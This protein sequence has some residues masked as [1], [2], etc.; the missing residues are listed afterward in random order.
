MPQSPTPDKVIDIPGVGPVAF[1]STMAP[2]DIETAAGRLHRQANPTAKPAEAPKSWLSTAV[3]WL[4]SIGGLAGGVIGGAGG[5][6]FG[7]GFGGVPGAV[8]GSALGGAAGEAL[9]QS[10][11]RLMGDNAPDSPIGA[12][13]DIAKQVGIQGGS[14]L[15]GGSVIA[16]MIKPV[17]NRL[18]ATFVQSA[19]KPGLKSTMRSV[20]KGADPEQIP[21]IKTLIDEGVNV[22]SAGIRKLNKIIGATNDELTDLLATAGGW[23]RPTRVATRA[24]GLARQ[25]GRQVNPKADVAAVQAARD[26]FL[27]E[28]QHLTPLRPSEAQ[29]IKVGTYKNLG[30]KAYAGTLTPASVEGQKAL[31]RGLKEDIEAATAGQ[32]LTSASGR[33][34]AQLNTREGAAIT[35]KEAVAR[36]VA[37][38]GNRDP[39]ALAWLANNPVAG[40]AF[41]M[42]RSPAIKSMLGRNL[43]SSASKA[44][45]V[46]EF[47]IRH[48]VSSLAQSPDDEAQ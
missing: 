23:V 22:S 8:G 4:P 1:P 42:E 9:R 16:P 32:G 39:V 43:Y 26:E 19:L 30:D 31:A 38:A 6:A 20:A 13:S 45:R 7:M 41:I 18:G 15:V 12:A 28:F 27:D 24:T 35:A 33:T 25:M 36:R 34:V 3:D 29:A 5:T 40:L 44:A 14:E 11:H 37:Q 47:V 10:A 21:V 2:A 48:V 46:P 17:V